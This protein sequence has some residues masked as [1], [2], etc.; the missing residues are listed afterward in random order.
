MLLGENTSINLVSRITPHIILLYKLLL[1][2]FFSFFK[3]TI[4]Q[5]TIIK[6]KYSKKYFQDPKINYYFLNYLKE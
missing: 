3:R 4:T 5:L 6:I 1:L 2:I